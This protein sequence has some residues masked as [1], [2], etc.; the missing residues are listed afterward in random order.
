MSDDTIPHTR[1]RP[2]RIDDDLWGAFEARVG[3]RK[4]SDK[5][6]QMMRDFL[7]APEKDDALEFEGHQVWADGEPVVIAGHRGRVTV[8]V[9][10]PTVRLVLHHQEGAAPTVVIIHE[11]RR[12]SPGRLAAR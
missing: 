10:G 3:K 7:N 5:I 12:S 9:D 2:I 8:T 4:C 6:R 11:P 1:H